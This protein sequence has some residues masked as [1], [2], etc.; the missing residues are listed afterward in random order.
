MAHILSNWHALPNMA[1]G[2]GRGARY[3]HPHRR[4]RHGKPSCHIRVTR[5]WHAAIAADS[6]PRTRTPLTARANT[7][8]VARSARHA[9]IPALPHCR[10]R[11]S[12]GVPLAS[13]LSL[14]TCHAP[15]GRVAIAPLSRVAA[16]PLTCA[17]ITRVRR[18]RWWPIP[19]RR[20]RSS[21]RAAS[22][23]RSCRRASQPEPWAV[24]ARGQSEAWRTAAD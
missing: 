20:A 8:R 22:S 16:C 23:K 5:R 1:G 18:R 15:T 10:R 13:G 24:T 9:T 21:R 17:V 12:L 7:A 2:G 14:P 3:A 4:R 19:R 6:T 11:S